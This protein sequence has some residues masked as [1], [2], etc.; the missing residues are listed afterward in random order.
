MPCGPLTNDAHIWIEMQMKINAPKKVLVI[1]D[2][3]TL[4]LLTK[5]Y[6]EGAGYTVRL[7]DNGRKGLGPAVTTQPDIILLDVMLPSL[8]GYAVCACLKES[9]ATANVPIV[10]ITGSR[11]ATSSSAV[12]RRVP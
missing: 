4:R 6:L 7:A 12:W 11:A 10:L 3:V 5:E 2:D 8:D 1:D 9:P